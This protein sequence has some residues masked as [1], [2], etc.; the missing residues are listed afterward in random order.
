MSALYLDPAVTGFRMPAEW[1]PHQGT[2]LSW[3]HN[4][5]TWPG[6]SIEKI[7]RVWVQ[8]VVELS[9]FEEVHIN[10]ADKT[11]EEKARVLLP[12]FSLKPHN[13]LFHHFSTNDAWIRDHGPIFIIGPEKKENQREK[14]RRIGLDWGYNA[15]GG[16]YPPFD[17]D[18]A[19]PGQVAEF[20][21]ESI[22][23]PGWIL[24]GG[25]I[26]VNG[27]GTLLTTESCLLNPN[28]NPSLDRTQI[29]ILLK[30][31]LGV[32]KILWLGDGIVG[33]DTDG[34]IDDLTRF[35]APNALVTVLEQDP[36]DENFKPLQDNYRRLQ[37]MTDEAGKPFEIHT[38]PMP[39][40]V[41]SDIGRLPASYANFY[42][43]NGLVLVPTF[44]DPQDAIALETLRPFF[45]GR[46]VVGLNCRDVVKGLGGI[47]CVTQQLPRSEPL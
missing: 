31:Y 9:A 25:S 16:K 4:P 36:R 42:I 45:P 8:M 7:Q 28:R 40:P 27:R 30:H 29:E 38:L 37:T 41:E 44:N 2:W 26:E 32:S 35:V 43:A 10:V 1:E 47:H 33:D 17:K 12:D 6:I 34:H 11:M 13:V 21:G 15:W 20:L 39:A 24:E 19:I 46:K 14:S 23:T 22:I 3:P 18:D 5:E